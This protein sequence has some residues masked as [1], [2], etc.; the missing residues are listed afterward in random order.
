MFIPNKGLAFLARN[1]HKKTKEIINKEINLLE[2][3]DICSAL[4]ELPAKDFI[5]DY[6]IKV[7]R[8]KNRSL[9]EKVWEV[10][11]PKSDDGM[12]ELFENETML[13]LRFRPSSR[14]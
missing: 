4:K 6:F 7:T 14:L 9:I 3:E 1:L 13:G 5:C 11:D 12:K 8:S 2:N 10:R